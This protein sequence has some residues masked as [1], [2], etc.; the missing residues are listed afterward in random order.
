M[1]E[2]TVKVYN[3]KTEWW[4]NDELHREDGPAIERKNGTKEW[5]L[6]GKEYTEEEY[7]KEI[8][9]RSNPVKE[10]TVSEISELLGYNIKIKS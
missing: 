8:Q 10:L 3:V 9:R 7:Y 4:L 1:K 5:W 6:N 2:Y